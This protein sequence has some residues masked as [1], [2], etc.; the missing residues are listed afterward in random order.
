M[1]ASP[2]LASARPPLLVMVGPTASG[3]TDLAIELAEALGGEIVSADSVQVYRGLDIGSGKATAEQRARVPHHCLDLVAPDQLFDAASYRRHAEAA[4]ADLYARGR[5]AVVTGGTGLYVRALLFGLLPAPGASPELRARLEEELRRSSVEQLHARLARVDPQLAARLSPR[6]LPR[7]Q[8]GLEVHEATGAPLSAWQQQHGFRRQ[9]H[10]ALLFGIRW[11]RELLRERI[12][13]RCR[14]MLA[15]GF[16]EEVQAL[17]R[18]GYGP[19]LRPMQSLGY[20][21][22]N[23]VLD[24]VL[25][26]EEALQLQIRNTCRYARRQ[27]TWF[28]SDPQ[29][30]WLPGPVDPAAAIRLARDALAEHGGPGGK[31]RER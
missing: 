9:L 23:L 4:L 25:G 2:P 10:P 6:D 20:R 8:R 18:A 1:S 17:R 27:M 12:A 26:L 14:A 28:G 13:R 24:G 31:R 5:L 19:A 16:L 3:K 29:V 21:E 30:C 22:M 11:E 7:I 15:T